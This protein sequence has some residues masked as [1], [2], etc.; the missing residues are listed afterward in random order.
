MDQ[1]FWWFIFTIIAL[2]LDDYF[3]HYNPRMRTVSFGMV[4]IGMT[5][6]FVLVLQ[7]IVR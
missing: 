4:V 7:S 2:A 1:R 6:L 3:I 5:A